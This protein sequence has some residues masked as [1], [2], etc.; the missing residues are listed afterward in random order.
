MIPRK[1]VNPL[2]L[3]CKYGGSGWPWDNTLK[4]YWEI[5]SDHDVLSTSIQM[6]L[7]T[8]L[9]ERVMICDFGSRLYELLFDPFNDFLK[10]ELTEI[11]RDVVPKWDPRLDVVSVDLEE[12]IE[13]EG[14]TI[15]VVY[16]DRTDPKLG[17][18]TTSFPVRKTI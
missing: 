12:D 14:V 6:I 2:C 8:M 16:K 7:L 17:E 3:S 9:G 13:N 18:I 11:V 4:S 15:H 10:A 1:I 5:K